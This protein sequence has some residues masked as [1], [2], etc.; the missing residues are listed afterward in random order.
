MK[1]E[2][3]AALAWGVWTPDEAAAHLTAHWAP[4][5]LSAFADGVRRLATGSPELAQRYGVVPLAR[6]IIRASPEA[7]FAL[8][9]DPALGRWSAAVLEA[10]PGPGLEP[11]V[12]LLPR[13]AVGAALAG[14]GELDVPVILGTGGRARIPTD[15]RQLQ[16]PPGRAI[17]V[18]VQGGVLGVHA[19]PARLAGPFEVPDGDAEGGKVPAVRPLSG[20]AAS[21][22]A[23][24]LA[25]GAT[26]LSETAPALAAEV[27]ALAP[28]LVPVVTP[29][30][31]S[32]SCSLADARGCIWLSSPVQPLVVA[33]TLV[34][35]ASHLKF[36][37][38]EDACTYSDPDDVPRFRVPWRPDLRPMRAVLM[39]LHA[40]VRVMRWLQTLDGGP[41]SQPAAEWRAVLE[42]AIAAA[43]VII[44]AGDGLTDAGRALV[45]AATD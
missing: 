2:R 12:A 17:R 11:L 14:G 21:D 45:A 43:L 9:R 25:A 19:R 24:R 34:H 15:G 1:P 39:G 5:A 16:G 23:T 44:R 4:R 35:E 40:W 3:A 13:L 8:A 28:T 30:E 36:F 41:W 42:E 20:A 29:P 18:T 38:L 32:H 37:H 6:R 7:R 27:L 10:S 26:V 22:A 31:V 33:E